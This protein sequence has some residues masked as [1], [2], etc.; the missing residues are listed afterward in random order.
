MGMGFSLTLP[1]L[2]SALPF[3][4]Q[5]DLLTY[6]LLNPPELTPGWLALTEPGCIA[7]ELADCISDIIRFNPDQVGAGDGLGTLVFYSDNS[8]GVDSLAD[9]AG[10]PN[11]TELKGVVVIPEIGPEG[12]NGA[13]YTPTE[14]QPGFVAGPVIYDFISDAAVPEPVS[15]LLVGSGLV[16]LGLIRR[17]GPVRARSS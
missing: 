6:D 1:A 7:A 17:R 10:L 16:G 15:L 2:S 8:D 4:L 11:F 12:A 5:D 3:S 9:I 14:G 13:S